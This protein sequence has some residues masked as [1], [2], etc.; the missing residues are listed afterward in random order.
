MSSLI[1][2]NS[3]T[4]CSNYGPDFC[5]PL[6]SK[7]SV[8]ITSSPSPIDSL[9]DSEKSIQSPT[10]INANVIIEVTYAAYVI[11]A[12][13]ILLFISK[14][15]CMYPII[16]RTLSY[17][18][19][20]LSYFVHG[21]I[22]IVLAVLLL[23]LYGLFPVNW[24]VKDWEHSWTDTKVSRRCIHPSMLMQTHGFSLMGHL[25]NYGDWITLLAHFKH[26]C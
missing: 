13:K 22:Q 15:C 18:Y 23:Y 9:L 24:V 8:Q 2:N 14:H 19:P 1:L 25:L 6:L 26:H 20:I 11:R 21:C 5:P 16:L 10:Q 4:T 17:L 12:Q 7:L 3:S